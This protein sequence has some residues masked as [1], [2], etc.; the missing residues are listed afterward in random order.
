MKPSLARIE[1]FVETMEASLAPPTD[2]R[3]WLRL[4]DPE[5]GETDEAA[6]AAHLIK[7]PEDGER[8]DWLQWV[9]TCVPRSRDPVGE[10]SADYQ[11]PTEAAPEKPAAPPATVN[12]VTVE[13]PAA[14]PAPEIQKEPGWDPA[15][16]GP[17]PESN[18]VV[19]GFNRRL[20]YGPS[21]FW[22]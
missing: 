1:R 21:G 19:A 17:A 11:L 8:L 15:L 5:Y 12:N 9:R 20:Y 6:I 14:S 3:R 13:K 18:E 2:H 16:D 22:P 7:H 4:L 10:R